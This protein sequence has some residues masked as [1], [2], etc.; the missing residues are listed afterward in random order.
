MGYNQVDESGYSKTIRP[1]LGQVEGWY[2]TGMM[3]TRWWTGL[4]ENKNQECSTN[5]PADDP[6][7]GGESC[8]WIPCVTTLTRRR[9]P[10]V[11]KFSG[12]RGVCVF[13]R[14]SWAIQWLHFSHVLPFSRSFFEQIFLVK[15]CVFCVA[16]KAWI[17]SWILQFPCFFSLARSGSALWNFTFHSAFARQILLPVC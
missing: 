16:N 2:Y 15:Q 4:D 1:D 6:S 13:R 3:P 17:A 11:V 12:L 9:T 8:R 10:M 7:L 14:E 5:R